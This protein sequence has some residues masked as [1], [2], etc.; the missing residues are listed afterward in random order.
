MKNAAI[1]L[2]LILAQATLAQA[3]TLLTLSNDRNSGTAAI[4]IQTDAQG[5]IQKFTYSNADGSKA[6]TPAQV[7]SGAVLEEQQGVQ[8]LVLMGQPSAG[9][10]A[11]RYVYNGMSG[12]YRSCNMNLVHNGANWS[13]TNAYTGGALRS[14]KVVTWSLG[15]STIQGLCPAQ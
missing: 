1:A 5:N 11:I 13:L 6:F 8:A 3:A 12:D 10:L 14:A 9:K 15:I 2:T 4:G 7:S